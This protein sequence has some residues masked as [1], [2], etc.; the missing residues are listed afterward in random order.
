MKCQL[1]LMVVVFGLTLS[2]PMLSAQTTPLRFA[3]RNDV[4]REIQLQP[5]QRAALQA[6]GPVCD[7]QC[8]AY[9]AENFAAISDDARLAFGSLPQEQRDRIIAGQQSAVQE[10]VEL[11]AID[12]ILANPQMDRFRQLWAQFQGASGLTSVSVSPA[13]DLS[14]D[15]FAELQDLQA[16]ANELTNAC[17]GNSSLTPDQQASIIQNINNGV[18]DQSINILNDTQLQTFIE[19]CGE[20]CAFD[21]NENGDQNPEENDPSN[22]ADLDTQ[23]SR[24]DPSGADQESGAVAQLQNQSAGSGSRNSTIAQNRNLAPNRSGNR[25]SERINRANHSERNMRGSR[26]SAAGRNAS[27]TR[28]RSSQS[29]VIRSTRNPNRA[30]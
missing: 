4:G 11:N 20:P 2:D 13:L 14:D 7:A 28:N 29:N 23:D 22:I 15:Q 24:L 12:D 8:Q 10:G 30:N 3:Q 21:P 25:N 19:L 17:L 16:G 6:L 1:A 9:L 18:I 26:G 27:A 5:D